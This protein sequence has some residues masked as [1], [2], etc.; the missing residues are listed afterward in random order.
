MR[1]II[2]DASDWQ[3]VDKFRNKPAVLKAVKGSKKYDKDRPNPFEMCKRCGFVTYTNCTEDYLNEFYLKDYRAPPKVQNLYTG[4]RKL[5]Y[6]NHFLSEYFEE[7]KDK[8]LD[9]CE[10]GAAFGMFLKWCK[11]KSPKSKVVGTEK[12]LSFRR[13]AYHEYGIV[14]D[15]EFDATKKYDLIASYKV[16]EHVLDIDKSLRINVECLKPDGRIYISIPAWFNRYN[17][18]GCRGASLETYYA[19]AHVN[20][21]TRNNFENLLKK[22][23][24]EIIKENH[25]YY[26]ET[27][28]CKRNDNI[29][30]EKRRQYD[31]PKTILKNLEAIKLSNDCY[32]KHDFKGALK[33]WKNFPDA[34]IGYYEMDRKHVHKKGFDF[35]WDEYLDSMLKAVPEF[36]DQIVFVADV[37]MR[38]SKWEKAI[39][40]LNDSLSLKPENPVALE[41][42]AHCFRQMGDMNQDPQGKYDMFKQAVQITK[43]LAAT[44]MEARSMAKTWIF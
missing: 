13:V 36:A 1:C 7:N 18:F 11:G 23:G 28:L 29:M 37:C 39:D 25:S 34:W 15:T 8:A 5:H 9:I 27:Y 38:Y 24:L 32:Q 3:N 19:M 4:E 30:K 12:T 26:E 6:H 42:L 21:W 44:S 41:K 16:A 22:V 31:N 35:I 20:V 33:A 10:I 43:H 17:N 40:L 14:L 2:C